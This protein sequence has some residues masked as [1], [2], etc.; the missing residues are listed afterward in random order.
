M[1]IYQKSSSSSVLSLVMNLTVY[2]VDFTV[3]KM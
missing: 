2:F 1:L 3:P